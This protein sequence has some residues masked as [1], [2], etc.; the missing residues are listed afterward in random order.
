MIWI[1]TFRAAVWQKKTPDSLWKFN[2]NKGPDDQIRCDNMNES[3][4]TADQSSWV[5]GVYLSV[6]SFDQPADLW[7]CLVQLLFETYL[8]KIWQLTI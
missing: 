3:T 6:D 8:I 4:E 2:D 7:L 1:Q 5:A